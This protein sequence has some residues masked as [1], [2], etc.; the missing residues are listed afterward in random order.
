MENILLD[1]DHNAKICD[2]GFARHAEDKQLLETFCGSL[3]YSA[4]EMINQKRYTGPETDIWS[5]GII[6]YTL[7]AGE[8]P[9]DDDSEIVMRRKIV[10]MDYHIPEYFSPEAQD[11]V[12]GILQLDPKQRLTINQIMRHPWMKTSDD[13]ECDSARC[14]MYSDVD[15][16]FS[17]AARRDDYDYDSFSDVSS[18]PGTPKHQSW[19]RKSPMSSTLHEKSR[20]INNSRPPRYSAPTVSSRARITQPHHQHQLFQHSVRSSLP[21][22]LPSV[23]A[24]AKRS[25]LAVEEP[26]MG[27]MEERLFAALTAAGFDEAVVRKMRTSSDSGNTLGAMWHMLMDNLCNQS[28]NNDNNNHRTLATH[29]AKQAVSA[30]TQTD[31]LI[32]QQQQP[33]RKRP[34]PIVPVKPQQQQQ[35][36][37]VPEMDLKPQPSTS[38]GKSGWLSSVKSWFGAKQQQEDHAKQSPSASSSTPALQQPMPK[39]TP[40]ELTRPMAA[41]NKPSLDSYYKASNAFGP[42]T[43][44]PIIARE[45]AKIALPAPQPVAVELN[46][47]LDKVSPQPHSV[48]GPP[49]STTSSPTEEPSSTEDDDDDDDSSSSGSSVATLEDDDDCVRHHHTIHQN[50]EIKSSTTPAPSSPH[51]PSLIHTQEEK[52]QHEQQSGSRLEVPVPT[53]YPTRSWPLAIRENGPAPLATASSKRFEFAA[54]RS[55]AQLGTYNELGRRKPLAARAI[56]EEEEEEE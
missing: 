9:F 24:A 29:G 49:R 18:S 33:V 15:S 5:L 17:S 20:F 44:R 23:R 30:G 10:N 53:P 8:L 6:L 42:T 50:T 55:R 13:D 51:H 21:S 39:F 2:F 43:A 27:P 37:R 35:Q 34:E 1:M 48:V 56:I 3:A 32:E 28:N 47:G 54:P 12:N 14:S 4:P 11:L 40:P 46:I 52:Q 38:T 26:A 22:S 25:S 36:H 19:N 41:H 16:I 31:D 7:L 45:P